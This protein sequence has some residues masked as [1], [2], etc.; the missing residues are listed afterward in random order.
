[1]TDT[2]QVGDTVQMKTPGRIIDGS[3]GTVTC[4]WNDGDLLNISFPDG[5]SISNVHVSRVQIV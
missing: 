3:V 2:I 5:S 4:T 1:M